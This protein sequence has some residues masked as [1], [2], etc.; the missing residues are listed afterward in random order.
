[1]SH[2]QE[3]AWNEI[4]E[5]HRFFVRWF[6][7]T[8]QDGAIDTCARSFAADFRIIWP[9]GSEHDKAPLVELLRAARNTSG[10]DYAIEVVKHHAV[11]LT[12]DLVLIT[13]DEL[14]QTAEGPN[15]R[16]ATALFSR[17]ADAPE[18]VVWRYLHQTWITA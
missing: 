5:R 1:M 3:L 18:G 13:F 14:Q 2:M 12:P 15:A 8:A 11:D 9:D 10:P 6:T 7:G 16:R 4:V 17:D